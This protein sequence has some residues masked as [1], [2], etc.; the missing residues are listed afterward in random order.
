[1]RPYAGIDDVRRA[2]LPVRKASQW[3]LR[4]TAVELTAAE[5]VATIIAEWEGMPRPY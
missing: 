1:M 3:L 5:T 4:L 2:G